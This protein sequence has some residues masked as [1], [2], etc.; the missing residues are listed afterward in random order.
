[1]IFAS[2]FVTGAEGCVCRSKLPSPHPIGCPGLLCLWVFLPN[3]CAPSRGGRG[4]GFTGQA[5]C[6][7][8]PCRD[9][10]LFEKEQDGNDR[11]PLEE[12]AD[13]WVEL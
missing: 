6:R 13:C 4:T 8:P 7:R 1:M 9:Y 12:A 10:F 2:A 3:V 5:R 11:R